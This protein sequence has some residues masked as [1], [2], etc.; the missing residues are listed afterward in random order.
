MMMTAQELYGCTPQAPSWGSVAAPTEAMGSTGY[1]MDGGWRTLVNPHNPLFWFGVLL[2]ST[3]GFAGVAG[4][5]RLGPAKVSA[6][7]GK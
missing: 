7:I 1:G 4:S 3:V 6:A 5:A 2:L